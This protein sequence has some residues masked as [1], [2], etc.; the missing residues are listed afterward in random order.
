VEFDKPFDVH[1]GVSDFAIGEFDY[2]SRMAIAYENMELD[3]F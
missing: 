1:M 2:A 3:S